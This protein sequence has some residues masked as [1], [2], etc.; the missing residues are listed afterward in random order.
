MVASRAIRKVNGT[1]T[2]VLVK[3]L[4]VMAARV[5]GPGPTR[6]RLVKLAHQLDHGVAVVVPEEGRLAELPQQAVQP[7]RRAA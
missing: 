5:L 2:V 1:A 3:P 7:T 4:I 6:L